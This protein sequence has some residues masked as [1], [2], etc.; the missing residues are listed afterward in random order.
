MEYD[1]ITQNTA[2]DLIWL[3]QENQ[4]SV[5]ELT[6]VCLERIN[7]YD[8]KNGLNSVAEI[9]DDVLEQARKLDSIPAEERGMLAGLPILVKD[10][11]DVSGMHTT[12]GSAALS[13]NLP[14]YDAPIIANLRQNGA[15]ILGKANMTELANYTS[16]EMPNGFSSRGGQVICA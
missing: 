9:N 15:L 11:I 2:L 8:G 3:L 1:I 5:E 6:R 7:T 13:D 12:A 10:N 4:L 14:L 16:E